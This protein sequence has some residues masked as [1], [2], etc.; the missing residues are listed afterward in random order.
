MAL[1][2]PAESVKDLGSVRGELVTAELSGFRMTNKKLLEGL[3][4]VPAGRRKSNMSF[5]V[6]PSHA[7]SISDINIQAE[8]SC[9]VW[10]R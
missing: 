2:Q 8:I 1:T 7:V 4:R 3:C 9:Y 10:C 6:T 5:N